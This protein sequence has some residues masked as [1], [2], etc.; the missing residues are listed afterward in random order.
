LSIL[1]KA[2]LP[3]IIALAMVGF[4]SLMGHGSA[5]QTASAD[6]GAGTSDDYCNGNG[7]PC[8]WAITD[9]VF[10][11]TDNCDDE[12]SVLDDD[13]T[14]IVPVKGQVWLCIEGDD[15]IDFDTV[16][17]DSNDYGT[18]DDAL[19]AATGGIDFLFTEGI[20]HCE[21]T[22]GLHTDSLIIYCS[23]G[24]PPTSDCNASGSTGDIAVL[25]TCESHAGS[26]DIVISHDE[27][28][29]FETIKCVA[30]PDSGT[31]KAIPSKVEIVPA[32]GSTQYSLIITTYKD[33]DNNDAGAGTSVTWTS[34]NCPII[35]IDSD[36]DVLDSGWDF[37]D[38]K[39]LFDDYNNNPTPDTAA[40]VADFV[41]Y[42]AGLDP[43]DFDTAPDGVETFTGH[44]TEGSSSTDTISAVIMSCGQGTGSTPGVSNVMAIANNDAD[45]TD[46]VLKVAVTVVGPPAGPIVVAA[47]AT[48]VTCGDRVTITVTVHD[49]KGQNVSDHTLVEAVSTL[50]GILGGTGAVA[51]NYGFV[52]PVSSTLAETFNGVATFFLLTSQTQVGTYDVTVST[53]GGG[54]VSDQVLGGLFSTPVQTGH[55]SVTCTA[56]VVAAAAAPTVTAPKTG[57]GGVTPP[58]TGDAGLA[59]TSSSSSWTLFVIAGVV[60]FA[61]AGVAS[62]KFARK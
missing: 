58:N 27:E 21:D 2:L 3:A 26:A 41:E 50:G 15:D 4:V 39:D 62:L 56:P 37:V 46:V 57:T 7:T 20:D 55:V 30:E 6:I 8:T 5:V 18:F 11:A 28:F 51:G 59:A 60:A 22:S 32:L 40:A 47:D 35:T 38:V 44:V 49:S 24:T 12:G 14:V 42:E 25:F 17:F 52:V 1:R 29:V 9:S 45:S 33:S 48:S 13:D 23:G 19:C 31:I 53:G 16:S 10:G 36:D 54:A 61:A 43:D 34:D